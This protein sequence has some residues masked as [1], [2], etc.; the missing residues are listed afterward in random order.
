MKRVV[1]DARYL[2]PAA[3]GIGRHTRELCA[4]MQGAN[5]ELAWSFVERRAGAALPLR[6]RASLVFDHA[7]YGPRT[8]LLLGRE[9]GKLG[10]A[11]LFHSP[12]HVL[13]RG[14]ACPAVLTMHDAF[15]FEQPKTSNYPFP[16]SW[17]EWGYFLWAVP[18]SLARARRVIS[19]SK[20]TADEI[21]KRVPDCRDKLRVVYHG[22]TES[23]RKLA[24]QDAVRRR[25]RELTGSD[26]PFFLCIGAVSPNKNHAGMLRAFARAF[27]PGSPARLAVVHRFGSARRL[28]R[29]ALA[30]GVAER[31]RP[32]GSIGDEDLLCLLNGALAFVFCSKLEG[33][34]LPVLEAM[35]AGCPVL[36]SSVSCLPEIA[37]NAALFA[38]P[39]DVSDMAAKL[40]RLYDEPALRAE[41]R[42][43]GFERRAAFS[44]QKAAKETLEVYDEAM[45]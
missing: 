43:R 18:D 39:Y 25:C 24:D 21:R 35:A 3:S 37:G 33:F 27:P 13:P 44:W 26:A 11:D 15:N 16:I 4:A 19:V 10:P 9:L 42:E 40:K 14:L 31:Y 32:L 28:E 20:T 8:S 1:L 30:L 6:S 22:V 2:G 23:F 5:P 38:D 41:L 7:P 17:L 45:S 36:T 34:G 12:F 29:L